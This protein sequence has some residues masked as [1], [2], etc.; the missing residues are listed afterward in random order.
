MSSMASTDFRGIR[1]SYRG[2]M[3]TFD[4]LLVFQG[5]LS[6]RKRP[7][8]LLSRGVDVDIPL[9]PTNIYEAE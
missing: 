8:R 5:V 7:I 1:N 3:P 6:V 4:D 9:R 2:A